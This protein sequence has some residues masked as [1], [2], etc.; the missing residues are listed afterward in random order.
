MVRLCLYGTVLNSVDTVE[1]SIRSVFRPD[2][3]IVITDGGSTD[4]T[5]ER[6]L[7]I[8]KDYNLR[9][10][11]APGSS[12]GLGRQLAL[13]RCPEN[14]YTT[15]FDL[16]NEYN[17]YFHKSIDWGMATGS[18]R[19]LPGHYMREYVISRG[20][21]RDLNYAE[22][23]ELW[24]RVGFDYYLPI[25]VGRPIKTVGTG[26]GREASRYFQGIT[27]FTKRTLRTSLD[28]IRGLGLKP[29]DLVKLFDKS[30]LALLLPAY[31]IA[32][33][34]GIYRYDKF[35]NNYEL[36]FYNLLKKLKDPVKEIKADERYVVFAIPCKLAYHIGFSWIDRR[37]RAIGLRPYKC[38]HM[39]WG[40]S[41]VG[42]RSL[43]AIEAVNDY[44]RFNFFEAQSCRPLEAAE[45]R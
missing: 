26:L 10:Y 42:L 16:D 34:Q 2:A 30:R 15:Y 38:R 40:K 12:R 27:G 18:P 32:S 6:L 33:L 29:I 22:D 11:R 21:W 8:S 39:S 36:N 7:E 25:V 44:L 19:P 28:L 43:N 20:G 35:L 23:N 45:E 13:M 24:A 4:G 41:I 5:Y 31:V 14:S 37:L 9:V 3:D 17:V 1:R